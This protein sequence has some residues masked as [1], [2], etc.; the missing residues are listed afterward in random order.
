[1]LADSV[2][3]ACS[4][5]GS[6]ISECRLRPWTLREVDCTL[7]GLGHAD[8][9]ESVLAGLRLRESN[10]VDADLRGADLSGADLSGARLLGARLDGADL[11]GAVLGADALV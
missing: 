4:L 6:T 11:R 1:V 8:L 10:L 3:E 5:L 7:T 9:R 2:L